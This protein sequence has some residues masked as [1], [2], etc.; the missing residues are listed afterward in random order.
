[1]DAEGRDGR[2]QA[3]ERSESQTLGLLLVCNSVAKEA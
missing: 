3:V 2:G 1:M